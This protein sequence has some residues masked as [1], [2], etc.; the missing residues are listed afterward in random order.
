M[1]GLLFFIG[2]GSILAAA[3]VVFIWLVITGGFKE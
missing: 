3:L 1:D 2:L